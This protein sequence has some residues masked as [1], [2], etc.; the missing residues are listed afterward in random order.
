MKKPWPALAILIVAAANT[1]ALVEVARNRGGGPVETIEL[2][3]RELP[4]QSM[5]QD[6]S[7]VGFLVRWSGPSAGNRETSFSRSQLEGIGF[8]LRLPAGTSG[9]DVSLLPRAALVVLEYDGAA[10]RR[11]LGERD[12]KAGA[13]GHR[14]TGGAQPGEPGRSADGIPPV[15]NR[16]RQ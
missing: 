9:K 6:N 4:L 15:P 3:E 13:E 14:I 8:D 10:Y 16:Y 5:G 11:W 1:L 2:T 12:K 7:A